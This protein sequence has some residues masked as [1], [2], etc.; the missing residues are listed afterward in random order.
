[1]VLAQTGVRG[2]GGRGVG[3]AWQHRIYLHLYGLPHRFDWCRAFL[4]LVQ[5]RP[6]LPHGPQAGRRGYFTLLIYLNL[7][8]LWL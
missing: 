7:A 5:T 6:K 2:N 8:A 1:V 3:L 4:P